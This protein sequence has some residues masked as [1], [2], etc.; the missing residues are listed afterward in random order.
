[1]KLCFAVDQAEAFRRGINCPFSDVEVEVDASTMTQDQR[2]LIAD[3]LRG[4]VV[5]PIAWM[6][7]ELDAENRM[8]VGPKPFKRILARGPTFQDLMDA[9]CADAETVKAKVSVME[10][11]AGH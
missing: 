11:A 3:R 8:A 5:Q 6:K 4:T 9:I 2:N 7:D 1:M 10:M